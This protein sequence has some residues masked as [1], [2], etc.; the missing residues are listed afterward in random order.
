MFHTY[1]FEL[2][3]FPV[4]TPVHFTYTGERVIPNATI[5]EIATLILTYAA[6]LWFQGNNQC[7]ND[8]VNLT[9]LKQKLAEEGK[10]ELLDWLAPYS[11]LA[12][13]NGTE[14]ESAGSFYVNL[15]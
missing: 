5:K 2:Y 4:S 14:R 8:T 9:I 6:D 3:K 7:M 10:H 13:R 12:L 1:Y 15:Q 11:D